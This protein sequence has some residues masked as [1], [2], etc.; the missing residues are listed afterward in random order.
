MT[1]KPT[2]ARPSPFL[3]HLSAVLS[4][5]SVA[6]LI[7]LF[8]GGVQVG[9]A[10][11]TGLMPVVRRILDPGYLPEDFGILLRY[12]HHRPFAYLVA[13]FTGLV[14]EDNALVIL[15]WL[16]TV[17]LSLSLYVFCRAVNLSLW[18]YHALGV[19]VAA[20]TALTGRGLETNTF[21][22][23]REAMPTTF[24]HAFVLFAIAGLLRRQ[25]GQVAL[26]AGLTFLFH[27][28]IGFALVLILLPFYLMRLRE[29]GWRKA[30]QFTLLFLLPAGWA[31]WEIAMMMGRGLMSQPFSLSDIRFRQP[32]HFVLQSPLTTIVVALHVV[33]AIAVFLWLRRRGG[34][35]RRC[36][37]ILLVVTLAIATLS[38]LHILDIYLLGSGALVKF[39]FLR[40]SVFLT[41]FGAVA[42]ITLLN[43][44]AERKST[45]ALIWANL[46]LVAIALSLY[47]L[48]S[49]RQASPPS[50]GV[51][52]FSE[53]DNDWVR[54]CQWV[55]RN[56]PPG[57]LFL[58]PPGNEGFT[59]LSERSTVVEFKIN[60]DGPQFLSA[61]YER[62]TDVAGGTLPDREGFANAPLL[63][64]AYASLSADSVRRIGE[65]YGAD[66]AVLIKP[67]P[68]EFETLYENDRY[69]VVRLFKV[70]GE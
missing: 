35:E 26:F 59:Y 65:K 10:N 67:A 9:T 44:L 27:L 31:F 5:L 41:L 23:N 17:L 12:Y 28:Q 4:V 66:Y 19:L 38:A 37:N 33:T 8:N 40:M 61:W 7:I 36:A 45:P 25:Y 34:E 39:Q 54:V 63:N 20:N 3:A 70:S 64:R 53:Q 51:R 14:G 1:L 21:I 16:G 18:A 30:L 24:A 57:V 62:L 52:K 47:L 46:A 43:T 32:G 48:P 15:K 55:S 50:F 2:A 29:F 6:A 22:G 60:P 13:A 58:S 68:N 56:A 42:L 49:T 11:H 69:K